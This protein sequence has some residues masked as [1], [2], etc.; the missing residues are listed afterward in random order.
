MQTINYL[1]TAKHYAE[2]E[3]VASVR[4]R[5][6]KLHAKRNRKSRVP[7]QIQINKIASHPVRARIE[8]GQVVADCECGGCEFVD[9]GEPIFFCCEC[10]NRLHNGALRPVQFPDPETWAEITRLVLLRPVDDIRGVD[11]CDRAAASRAVIYLEQADG[12]HLP[13]TRSWNP[14]E[15]VE[16]LIRE[17]EAVEKWAIAQMKA[18]S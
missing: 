15:T 17:N 10:F 14:N 9:P 7:I 18:G 8:L 2:R 5:I 11:D 12:R 6:L 13:L 1:I 3:G 16:D 4:D